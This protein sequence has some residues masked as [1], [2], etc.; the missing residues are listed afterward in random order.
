VKGFAR[1]VGR[2]RRAVAPALAAA[3]LGLFAHAGVAHAVQI[4]E[5]STGISAGAEPYGIAAGPDGNVWFTELGANRIGRITPAGAVSEFSAGI[6]AKAGLNGIAAGADGNLWF[7][8]QSLDRIGRITPSGVVTEF[9]TGIKKSSGPFGIAAGPD[10]N[11]WFTEYSG[12]QIGRITPA[13]VVTEFKVASPPFGIA[14]GP[15]GN[16]WFTEQYGD[17]IGRITPAGVVTEFAAGITPGAAPY[18]IAEGPDG[19]LWFTEIGLNRVGR[20]TPSGVVTEF[21]TG[22]GSGARPYGIAAGP[23]G[24]VWFTEFG[25]D[26]LAR[27]TPLGVVTEYGTGISAGAAPFG[28]VTGP[29]GNLWST[30]YGL[31]RIAGLVPDFP[32]VVVTGAASD[33]DHMT[34]TVNGTVRPRNNQTSYYVEYGLDTSYG[35]QSAPQDA[36][37][38]D[39]TLPVSVA[40]SGLI[41]GATYHYRFTATSAIGTSHGEDRTFTTVPVTATG[42]VGGNVPPT[43]T[44]SLSSAPVSFQSFQV[45]VARDYTA[46]TALTVTSSAGDAQLGVADSSAMATGFLVNGSF[47]LRSPLQAGAT[48]PAHGTLAYQPLTA[49][50]ALLSY[51][52]PV[53]ND[54]VVVS[55]KQSIA[56]DEPLRTGSYA[57]TLTYTLTT[58][59]P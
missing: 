21:T 18:T 26:R 31:S 14:T 33:V 44:L 55:F 2:G 8:E 12:N 49:P 15:D 10:G 42:G 34:A 32:P 51:D 59:N 48:N 20:I 17:R 57:K 30:E 38:G 54:P 53:A 39:A 3:A 35:Q 9:S 24:N 56:A 19:N 50:V 27:I 5:F 52:G 41:P 16:L 6:S 47:Q 1:H 40:L 7:T 46:T 23:D 4:T 43:L 28:I 22:I 37:A 45:G 13:G 58:T 29:D 25:A 11:V 36:G